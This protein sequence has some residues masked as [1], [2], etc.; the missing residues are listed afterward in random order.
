MLADVLVTCADNLNEGM[1]MRA[2]YIAAF[3]EYRDDLLDLMDVAARVKRA[4]VAVQPSS[5]FRNA[6]KIG[7][8]DAAEQ[9]VKPRIIIR[10]PFRLQ[11]IILIGAAI[12]SALSVVVG[13]IA[14]ILMRNR[15]MQRSHQLPSG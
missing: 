10:N 9:K 7:L 4:L 3:P 12:G 13:I 14:A 2:E 11:K 6:L 1:D 5:A 15:A 8:L